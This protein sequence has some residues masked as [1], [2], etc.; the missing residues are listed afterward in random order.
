MSSWKRKQKGKE[1]HKTS[2]CGQQMT[3]KHEYGYV[4]EK[5]GKAKQVKRMNYD[6]AI[7]CQLELE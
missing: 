5:C 1:L 3:Y 6:K 7:I 4:C 2:C